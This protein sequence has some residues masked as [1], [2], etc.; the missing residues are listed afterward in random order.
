MKV[1]ISVD[2]EGIIVYKDRSNYGEW[3]FIYDYTQDR[4]VLTPGQ[5]PQNPQNPQSPQTTPRPGG[6]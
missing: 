3:E 1:L 4:S 5:N 6:R 2:M